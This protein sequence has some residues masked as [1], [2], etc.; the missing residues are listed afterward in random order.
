[1]MQGQPLFRQSWDEMKAGVSKEEIAKRQK[2]GMEWIRKYLPEI[3]HLVQNP[4]MMTTVKG[5][6]VLGLYLQGKIQVRAG[7]PLNIYKHEGFH[8]FLDLFVK[9]ETKQTMLDA[10]KDRFREDVNRYATQNQV[11]IKIA[12]EEIM[13]ELFEFVDEGIYSY[14]GKSIGAKLVAWI[15]RMIRKM[16]IMLD[17][18]MKV[19]DEAFDAFYKMRREIS[20]IDKVD[21]APLYKRNKSVSVAQEVKR[22]GGIDPKKVYPYNLREDFYQ[23]GLKHVLRKGGMSIGQA[24]ENMASNGSLPN[25]KPGDSESEALM[26]ALKGNLLTSESIGQDQKGFEKKYAEYIEQQEVPTEEELRK[27]LE[28][29]GYSQQAIEDAIVLNEEES[30]DINFNPEDLETELT[31]DRIAEAGKVLDALEK[32]FPSVLTGRMAKKILQEKTGIKDSS[33]KIT[34]TESQAL[35]QSLKDKA[36]G[37]RYGFREGI[38]QGKSEVLQKVTDKKLSLES[39]QQA[40]RNY[41]RTTA[42]AEFRNSLLRYTDKVNTEGQLIKAYQKVDDAVRRYNYRQAILGVRDAFDRLLA[43]RNIDVRFK[44]L[45]DSL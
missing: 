43:A 3:A 14:H 25:W 4:W 26:Q 31:R 29:M 15:K 18:K 12:S 30:S 13:A 41:I 39:R 10:V 42:P 36:Q 1:V 2:E 20:N 19:V 21:G 33:Q 24:A 45:I 38:R 6:E 37:A 5:Q 40:I 44:G 11:S 8:A 17:R 27:S 7:Q 35:R 32:R 28:S 22:M 23:Q 9:E 34:M 16:R